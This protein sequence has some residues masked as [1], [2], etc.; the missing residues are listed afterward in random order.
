MIATR[1]AIPDVVLFEPK[2]FGDERGFF[3]ES[4]NQQRFEAAIGRSVNF[5]QD[6]HSRSVK[7]VLRGLHYQ[8]KQP[9]GKLV[10]VVQGEVFDVAVDLRKSSTTFGQWV[11]VHL[12]A[13]NKQQLWVPEGFAH[14]FVVLSDTAEFLYKTTDYYAPEYER[15][16]LWNDPTL[17]IDWPFQG[18]AT[19]ATKDATAKRLT[20]AEVFA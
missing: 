4:F 7:S 18:E 5:V 3:F 14:G 19:L 16:L 2:V 20:E 12:R 17:A 11:G 8:I 15:S 6:N 1:L 13:D 10:R 9:Q